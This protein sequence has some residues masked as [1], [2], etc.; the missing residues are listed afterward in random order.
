MSDSATS[1]KP[2]IRKQLR[3]DF[4]DYSG[5]DYFITICTKDKRHYFGHI[6]DAQ[7]HLSSIGHYCSMQ[8]AQLS[9]LHTFVE[10]P[11]FVVMPNHIHM[12]IS[13]KNQESIT[14]HPSKSI[15]SKVIAGLKRAVTIFSK[16][17][18]IEFGW[19][20]S[21]HDHIIRGTQD[22]N[23]I[24]AYIETNVAKWYYDCYFCE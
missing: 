19:Q 17:K 15:L 3:A 16:E 18:N 11:L 24:A 22:G 20:R 4:H 8:I 5:G 23:R 7:M 21:F 1:D 13:I 9:S 14:V 2:L 12:I 10:V 6:H